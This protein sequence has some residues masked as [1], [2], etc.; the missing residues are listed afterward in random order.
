MNPAVEVD[1]GAL[2][3]QLRLLQGTVFEKYLQGMLGKVDQELRHCD[4]DDFLRRQGRA[5]LL[6]ELLD[7]IA[8]ARE[9]IARIE[10]PKPNMS[11]SF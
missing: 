4:H 2:C 5:L 9:E 11:K 3:K 6:E 10:R 1:R 7:D 8:G